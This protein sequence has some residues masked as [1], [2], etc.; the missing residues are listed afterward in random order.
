MTSIDLAA[1]TPAQK[2]ALLARRLEQKKQQARTFPAS[3]PQQRLWFLEQLTPG[4]AAY[5]IPGAMRVH[6]ELDLELWRRCC[7]EIARRHE[8]L[9][10]TFDEIDGQPV[11]VIAAQGEPEF[12]VVDVEHL[13]GAQGEEAIR[14]LARE[15]FTRPFDLRKGPLLRIKFL[16]LGP[17]EHVLL[18]TMHHIVGDLWSTAVAF[19]ELAGLYG[20]MRSGARPDLP[21]LPIQYADYAAWQHERLAGEALAADLAYWKDALD[22]A[23]P[24]LDLPTDHPRP[25]V[26]G[27]RGGT[28]PFRLSAQAADRL[29]ALCRQEGVT[30]FMALLAAFQVMLRRYSGQDDLVV[31]VPVANRGRPEVEPLI[32]LFVN[33][34]PLRTDLSGDPSFR[35]LLGRVR[36]VCLGAFAHQE[37]P[38]ERLVEQLR[39]PRDLSRAPIFQ[40]CFIYQNI[41]VPRLDAAGLRLEPLEIDSGTAR[42]DLTLEVFEQSEGL[43][44]C[45]EFNSDLF[46]GASAEGMAEHLAVLVQNLTAE[47]DRPV[48]HVPMLGAAE[49]ERLLRQWNDTA[50]AWPEALPAHRRFA[51]QARRQPDA[52][53]VQYEDQLLTY[54]ELDRRANRLAHRLTRLGV[55]RDALVGICMERC[56]DMVVAMLA[57]LKAGGAYIPIDPGFPPERI[58]FMLED[59]RLRVLLT[60]R[61]VLGRI[62]AHGAEPVCVD[63]IRDELE[64]EPCDD[65]GVSVHPED[66][67][68]VIYTSG[69]TGRPKGVQIPHRALSNFLLAMRQRPGIGPSDVLLAVTTFSFDI[70]MLELLLPL[71]EGA[72]VVL[73]SRQVATD[74]KLLAEALAGGEVTMLQATPSTWR[75][76]LDFGWSGGAGLRALAGGEALPR[77]LADRLLDTGAT[78]WNMYGPTETT[79][80]SSACRVARGPV[81]I[82]EP[83][84]NTQLH[85]LDANGRLVPTGVPGE[86][87]IGGDGLARGYLGRPQ[88]TAERFVT[89]S[90]AP[91]GVR[92]YR[93]G[94]LVRR[95][96]D[97]SI[98]YLGRLDRQTK[99]RGHRI[100][101]GEIESVLARQAAVR[102]CAVIVREDVPGDQR[103]VAYVV[104]AGEEWDTGPQA[105]PATLR[106][107]LGR[108]LP[109]YMVPSVFV[110]LG[111]LPLTPN[112][113]T[114]HKA[115]PAPELDRDALAAAYVAPRDATEQTL[116]DLFARVL[117]VPVVGAQDDF[118]DLGGHSLLATR[119]IAQARTAFGVE[120]R[121]RTLFEEPTPAG[122]ARRLRQADG[123]RPA[124]LP[125]SRPSRLPLS[126][127]QRRLWFLHRLEGP[128]ATYNIPL[129]IRLSGRL[130]VEALRE[131]LADVVERHEALRTTFPETDGVPYQRILDPSDAGIEL[132]VTA[133]GQDEL[134]RA[135][136]EEARH[137]F[138]LSARVPLHGR[139]FALAPDDHV[140]VLVMHHIAADGWSL[141]P[142][143]RDLVAAYRARRSGRR[144]DW[145]PLRVQYADYTLWQEALLGDP[146]DPESLWSRQLAYWRAALDGMPERI[147][148]PVDRPHP[149]QASH[150]GETVTFRWDAGLHRRL[151]DLARSSNASMFMLVHAALAALLHRLG[152]G[153]DIPIGAATAGRAD[154]ATE[155]LVGLF[156]NTLVLRVD[157]SGAPSFRTLLDQVRERSLDAYAQQ[158]LPLDALVEALKP[159]RS[160]SHHPLFQVVLSWQNTP[161]ATLALPDLHARVLP[162][163]TGTARMDLAL[164]VTQLRDA[165]AGPAGIEGIAEYNTD[166]FTRATVS[167]IVDR[168]ERVLRAAAEDPDI[169]IDRI[170]LLSAQERHWLVTGCNETARALPEASLPQLFEA[171]AGR[172]PE[173]IAVVSGDDELSYAGLEAAANRL[174]RRLQTLGVSAESAVAV[175]MQR[176]TD[177]LVA[178]LAIAKAG[179]VYVPLDPRYPASRMELIVRETGA[180][181]LLT[182]HETPC[183]VDVPHVVAVDHREPPGDDG[184]GVTP[185]PIGPDDLAYVMYTSGSTGR[186]KGV[187]VTHRNVAGLAL[188]R[189]WSEGDHKRVLMHS[190]AAFDA[191]TYEIWVPL[192]SGGTV[193]PAP[194]GNLDAQA[195]ELV[196]RRHGVTAVFLTTALFNL[197]VEQR[198]T[199]LSGLKEVWTGGEAV[200]PAAFS[201]ALRECPG[202]AFTHVYGPTET[203]TFALCHRAAL[204]VGSTVPIGRPMDNTRAYVL[205]GGL[206]P[207]PVSVP[208]ELYIAGDGVARG[209][210]DRPQLTEERFLPDPFGPA[211]SRMYRTGDIVRR[212]ADGAVEFLGRADEQVK[213][214]GFRI[215]LGEIET[216]LLT[217]PAVAQAAVA[218][219]EE[220]PGDKRLVGYLVPAGGEGPQPADLRAHL[221]EQLPQ[222]ML[223]GVF[224][225]MD[226]LPLTANGKV[227]RRAL[228]APDYETSAG[229]GEPRTPSE[230]MLCEAF[231]H[232][233]G[234][235]RVGI[236]DNFFEL[237]G[238]SLLATRLISHIASVHG[239]KLPLHDLFEHPTVADL[240]VRVAGPGA[241]AASEAEPIPR[242]PRD[243]AIPLSFSQEWLCA[244][245]DADP[246]DTNN[247]VL[248]AVVLKGRLDAKALRESLDGI[249]DRHEALRARVVRTGGGWEQRVE[250]TG[251][252]PLRTVDLS[253]LGEAERAAQLRTL[254]AEDER[255][256]FRIDREPLVRA[257]LVVLAPDESVLALVMHHLVTDNWSYGVLVAEL[258]EFYE[259]RA[260]GREPQLPPLTVHYPDYAAW[261]RRRIAQGALDEQMDYWRRRLEALPPRPVLRAPAHQSTDTVTGFTQGFAV[262]E[263]TTKALAKIAQEGGATLF[264]VLT[265]AYHVLLS[266]YGG[267]SQIATTFPAAGR[268]HPGTAPLIGFFVNHLIARSDLAGNPSF[269]ELVAHMREETLGAYAHQAAP[270]WS[271]ASVAEGGG[272]PMRIQFNLLN[273]TVPQLELHGLRVSSL[274][275]TGGDDYVFSE[276]VINM[277]PAAVDLS[278]IMREHEGRLRGIWLYSPERLDPRALAAMLRHWPALVRMVAARPDRGVLDLA[279]D[280]IEGL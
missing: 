61:E 219:R 90:L 95:R 179:G 86:L 6:G 77:E 177:L 149:A 109:E 173:R 24:T 142:L 254:I 68:Y 47:P 73:A 54:G 186:P 264:M 112:G 211:G 57:V 104:T 218:V 274:Q 4:N 228:P 195:L 102:D 238:H 161:E 120:M 28:R 198:P 88:L 209:Y 180:T 257:T 153:D 275:D 145:Q 15:E 133:I 245:A 163:A 205:D 213:I 32:G 80:W 212:G 41:P 113:K 65:P 267:G 207:V 56:P 10:T 79:I 193:V 33:M 23:A 174:A 38:F 276:V 126:F 270:L 124:L 223:P 78:L 1:L 111:A 216:A 204:P 176:S 183:P 201:R 266:A 18:L 72:R 64:A 146:Q 81:S 139:L 262:D 196:V 93:T 273:A 70:C 130:D 106:K 175:L 208:G 107:A 2:R 280:L 94:D 21:T 26:L 125:A 199:A 189:R 35:D 150:R 30:P 52:P 233:L 210:L 244:H 31:G 241:F 8:S 178:I 39:P 116:C 96:H 138:D 128:S 237:G 263:E 49:E 247:N 156:V 224:V 192:L 83:I 59:S 229:D 67:A 258:G 45:F 87:Y 217:H 194:P 123:A 253:H 197:I 159:T 234:T 214:R 154:E 117:G 277:R 202:T 55:T 89:S 147:A 166:V 131:A 151:A 242:A 181:V 278:L 60:Q 66:L 232:I 185:A 148:L 167:S 235:G 239:V 51:Q 169:P 14:E 279:G 243:A 19:R 230:Q 222:Y 29:R 85:V 187:A 256:P 226:E 140:L 225:V 132:A 136:A 172:T 36:Q 7:Q 3:F 105:L 215:E 63:A 71:A 84:A 100:E 269:R 220:Q 268:D 190:P 246:Q 260:V 168:L 184:E 271:L 129:A 240:A 182:D 103:L 249:A 164:A 34:L 53:A 97:G 265:A 5:N 108:K 40:V 252:W 200:S 162:T 114:D 171:Q 236:H 141:A 9:R 75:M 74:G 91:G 221:A 152:A 101:L 251:S 135:V 27:T 231:A 227:D 143:A 137:A 115:L 92:L 170:D 37:L 48:A 134:A 155:D 122:L 203:T 13:R 259:S 158:D 20:A 46:D 99:L 261:Q 157:T 272:G 25:A 16:R 160:L 12:G 119:L 121:V 50:C 43:S 110:F 255:R 22:G 17:R 58:S 248:T 118:F 69:S 42:F 144:P 82:G 250:A 206:Q 62:T 44:G 11:Q 188:D 165:A 76:L 127:A 191:S 98:E